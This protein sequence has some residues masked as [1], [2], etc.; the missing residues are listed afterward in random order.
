MTQ[1]ILEQRLSLYSVNLTPT[2]PKK[3]TVFFRELDGFSEKSTRLQKIDGNL[4]SLSPLGVPVH[5]AVCPGYT[6]SW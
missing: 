5:G 6:S 4:I 2:L 1:A 3:W